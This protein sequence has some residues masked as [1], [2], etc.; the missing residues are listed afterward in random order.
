MS[1]KKY[2]Q[3]NNLIT[4][5]Y[6]AADIEIFKNSKKVCLTC[7]WTSMLTFLHCAFVW[8]FY[9][10]HLFDFSPLCISLN[11]FHCAFLWLFSTM[12]LFDLSWM[13]MEREENV[14]LPNLPLVIYFRGSWWLYNEI[15]H[16]DLMPTSIHSETQ[17]MYIKR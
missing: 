16:P 9:T 6:T 3:Y 8:L 12:H 15:K 14:G 11:I 4:S 2:V 13:L 1:F 10:V 5:L 17:I 7:P